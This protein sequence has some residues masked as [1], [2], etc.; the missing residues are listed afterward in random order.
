MMGTAEQGERLARRAYQQL[1]QL[2]AAFV[3]QVQ[4]AG[5]PGYSVFAAPVLARGARMLYEALADSLSQ[6]EP[7][8]LLARAREQASRRRQQGVLPE[9]L[10][11]VA[12]IFCAVLQ[13]AGFA[14]HE[15]PLADLLPAFVDAFTASQAV[16]PLPRPAPPP[17]EESRTP[18]S[19]EQ[20]Q[21]E[22]RQ[23][24]TVAQVSRELMASLEL[25]DL[26]RLGV[27]RIATRFDYAHVAVYLA[28]ELSG[29]S[30]ACERVEG[31]ARVEPA[32]EEELIG[33]VAAEGVPYLAETGELAVP[34]R[35]GDQVL[36]VLYVRGRA[37]R[38]LTEADL[39]SMA[40]LGLQLGVAV[41]RA[42]AFRETRA[43][44][45]IAR[46][47]SAGPGTGK[48]LSAIARELRDV[49]SFDEM[50]VSRYYEILGE[51]GT[52][53]IDGADEGGVPSEVRLPVDASLPG[54][55]LREGQPLIVADLGQE[56]VCAYADAQAL[57]ERGMR[58]V[59]VVPL[60]TRGQFVATLNLVSA[61]DCAFAAADARLMA[62]VSAQLAT[63]LEN[64]EI[65]DSMQQAAAPARPESTAFRAM[66]EHTSEAIALVGPDDVITYA[67][68]AFHV[69]Y[70]Y[71]PQAESLAGHSLL[72][73]AVEGDLPALDAAI[74]SALEA[75]GLWE[76]TVRHRRRDGTL[77]DAAMALF[78][79][80]E[81]DPVAVAASVR[82]VTGERKTMA[83]GQ[84]L[85]S[86]PE[87]GQLAPRALECI[88]EDTGIDRAGMVLYEACAPE[89]PETVSLVAVYDRE[90]G[91]RRLIDELSAAQDRPFAV[92]AYHER[93]SF[94]VP[95]VTADNRLSEQG[96]ALLVEQGIV[97]VL[98]L[99]MLV[100]GDVVG[101]VSL[102]W[103]SAVT[104]AADRVALYEL[105]VAQV[106]TA[107]ENARQ[108]ARRQQAYQR[109]LDRR[110]LEVRTSIELGQEVGSCTTPGELF[111]RVARLLAERLGYDHVLLYMREREGLAC[112]AGSSE[113]GRLLHEQGYRRALDDGPLGSAVAQ[114]QAVRLDDLA[115]E[116]AW[117]AHP[118]LAGMRS[119]LVVPLVLGSDVLGALEVYGARPGGL[120]D[121]DTLLLLGLGTQ[122]AMAIESQRVLREAHRAQRAAH[123]RA[124]Q[125]ELSVGVSERISANLDLNQLLADIVNLI[126]EG[127]D[128]D[129]VE[130]CLV[131]RETGDLVVKEGTGEPG[132]AAKARADRI[133]VGEG[134]VGQAAS[135]G[136]TVL[137][138][139]VS[140][141]DDRVPGTRAEIA[142][143]LKLGQRVLGVLDVRSREVGGLTEEDQALLE[144]LGGQIAVAVRNAQVF[145]RVEDEVTVFQAL[146]ENSA[147]AIAMSGL[148]G[149]LFYAN[150]AWYALY[151]YDRTQDAAAG[152]SVEEVWPEEA[153]AWLSQALAETGARQWRG[154]TERLRDDHAPLRIDLTLYPVRD[155][156]GRAIGVAGV[157]R[158]VTRSALSEE[159]AR[160]IG[161]AS[162]QSQ[163]G[164][165]LLRAVMWGMQVDG[166]QVVVYEQGA[167][168]I[169]RT[170]A[171][172]DERQNAVIAVDETAPF[173]DD[174]IHA[175]VCRTRRPV[176]HADP[177]ALDPERRAA[178][179]AR[180]IRST[181]ALPLV[182]E[183][184][185]VQGALL[186]ERRDP[187]PYDGAIAFLA[188][189]LQ[190]AALAVANLALR[191]AQERETRDV[192]ERRTAEMQAVTEVMQTIAAAGD[193]GEL[194]RRVVDVV[195]ERFG[196]YHV[197][198]YLSR[199]DQPALELA[200]AHGE[201]VRAEG[202]RSIPPEGGLAAQAAAAGHSILAPDLAQ[203][204]GWEPD[205]R[206][207]E[208]RSAV[209]VPIKMGE[210]VLGVLHVESDHVGGLDREAQVL[211]EGLCGQIAIAMQNTRLLQEVQQRLDQ[212]HVLYE[213][214]RVLS[215]ATSCQ[216]L[217][218][219]AIERIAATGAS[220]CEFLRYEQR[221]PPRYVEVLASWAAEGAP[222]P[223]GA[224]YDLDAYPPGT[225]VAEAAGE[226]VQVYRAED[227]DVPPSIRAW[228]ASREATALALLPLRI[229][230]EYLGLLSIEQHAGR[231]FNA[232]D[233]R[234][235]ETVSSQCSVTLHDLELIE[236]TQ[237]Q[238]AELQH[239]YDNV[240]RLADQV[241]ELSSPVVQVWDDV[242]VLPLVGAIDAR[243]AMD[244]MESLLN[245][246]VAYQAEQVIIDITGVPVV[247]A[248]VADYLLRTI[249]AAS[250]LGAR[251]MIV[252]VRS[253][254]ARAVVG[255]GLDLSG[256]TTYS[257][258][259]AGIQAAL[260]STG[261]A[262]A[263]L[264]PDQEEG[265]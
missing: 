49:L 64:A 140:A 116:G 34:V 129:Y 162:S 211:L 175:Q 243:R 254:I 36:G 170:V 203:W 199:A 4:D 231:A 173:E 227:P 163:L 99:P 149:R 61:R 242:L 83:I 118:L 151:G 59:L 41:Q 195:Q 253:E 236:Q 107:V 113:A 96:R 125:L 238:L 39:A 222:A 48:L 3:A 44:S 249:R 60:Q 74:R 62:R 54:R 133:G 264:P 69:L 127:F 20:L 17:P 244:A 196:Y 176:V 218:A 258:L 145:G 250:M 105:V 171:A 193:L 2:A 137:V 223:V 178:W 212:V 172:Y 65:W 235:Y 27:D 224:H 136:R 144:G 104:L 261:Y 112:V 169:A 228:C 77:F 119:L 67:N 146:A 12:A 10:A 55:A 58:S 229:G 256:V 95:D 215:T 23:L 8:L 19:L 38:A 28:D 92:A 15:I 56:P 234:F 33:S 70:G 246:I 84:V 190:Y 128:Y 188:P 43:A 154:Q 18:G 29:L 189:V 142:V 73:F 52:V 71:D 159:L 101:L 50:S 85:S 141:P 245:G 192:L 82:D 135:S 1:D 76:G 88:V 225:L 214:T 47:V 30:L 185:Q 221:D 100:G 89:G 217:A 53:A 183:A 153:C 184:S 94:L 161:T 152:L 155:R 197:R 166:G 86:T 206:L 22:A 109:A 13:D 180:G 126:Q 158:D 7:E 130:V 265:D 9:E 63:A 233:L 66:V 79:V 247:D 37:P 6:V 160:L 111:V 210:Q 257:N 42:T 143:P 255:L 260:E 259:R 194:F 68:R 187:G 182:T 262:I 148:D 134:V 167:P 241:R 90:A 122:V 252:G 198:L 239:S 191:E 102:S 219:A 207:P 204:A 93:Q 117:S 24:E 97:S 220:R 147:D 32:P 14:T 11:Q 230:D 80:H 240:A 103:R 46:A 168:R 200:A 216:G 205:P 40:G 123:R 139:E 87:L 131:D 21:R 78:A 57:R 237:R 263:P 114:G 165:G 106:A 91:G 121:D 31:E 26:L 174:P 186:L 98:V 226:G 248:A 25:D 45:A 201:R 251:C 115:L 138:P 157:A 156:S 202:D 232:D 35:A 81:G 5:L 132:Q 75:S 177:A 120:T 181:A 72:S 124:Q 164:V 16:R 110:L 209:A 213:T 208:A 51:V 150:P 179:E 108:V